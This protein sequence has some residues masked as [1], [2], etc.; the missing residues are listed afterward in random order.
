MS[1][2][3]N[4][5]NH[6]FFMLRAL[7]QAT[8][9]YI[10][11]EVPIGAIIVHDNKIIAKAY[12][13]VESLKDATAHAEII[14][15]TQASQSLNDWRLN[16]CTL[17]V[18]KEPCFMCF[19]ALINSRIKNIYIGLEDSLRGGIQYMKENH[20]LLHQEFN[21]ETGILAQESQKLIQ[22]FFKE[23]RNN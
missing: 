19:G 3:L 1:E 2:L 9:A 17:Y 23:K 6:N 20:K 21:I 7:E 16:E 15:I 11:N 12:N 14:A 10:Q 13:R 22:T 4:E 5:R 18:T 8:E